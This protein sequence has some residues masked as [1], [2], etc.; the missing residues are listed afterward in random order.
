[1]RSFDKQNIILKCPVHFRKGRTTSKKRHVASTC[2]RCYYISEHAG[3][4]FL[5]VSLTLSEGKRL[6]ARQPLNDGNSRMYN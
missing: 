5:S 3:P 1:M 6:T 4:V 2:L